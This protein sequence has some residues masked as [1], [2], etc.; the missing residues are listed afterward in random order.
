MKSRFG[1]DGICNNE[2]EIGLLESHIIDKE[3][4]CQSTRNQNSNITSTL[5]SHDP[6]GLSSISFSNKDTKSN[7]N[8]NHTQKKVNQLDPISE[9]VEY[10]QSMSLNLSIL[11]YLKKQQLG[12]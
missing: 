5:T 3:D 7:L 6:S 8:I 11:F 4:T 12:V 1:G 10:D 2:E 9:K